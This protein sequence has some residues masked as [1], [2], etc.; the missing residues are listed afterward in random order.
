M[1][2]E[3]V[4]SCYII[5]NPPIWALLGF[6]W[7]LETSLGREPSDFFSV[8][9]SSFK[10]LRRKVFFRVSISKGHAVLRILCCEDRQKHGQSANRFV[11]F[12]F[13]TL[14]LGKSDGIG[15]SLAC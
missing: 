2:G 14:G 9:P 5:E 15:S 12:A 6:L 7:Y 8:V 1:G 11:L 3:S 4:T 10:I 13:L